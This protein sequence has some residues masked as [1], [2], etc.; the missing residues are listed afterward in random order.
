MSPLVC[1]RALETAVEGLIPDSL[2]LDDRWL[3]DPEVDSL[4]TEPGTTE[5]LDLVNR[6]LQQFD[7]SSTVL[8]LFSEVVQGFINSPNWKL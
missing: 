7:P 8:P 4:L 2:I 5:A 6:V 3:S 1:R